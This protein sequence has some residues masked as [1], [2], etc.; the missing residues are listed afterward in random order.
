M[1]GLG[2]WWTGAR[3]T[4][5]DRRGLARVLRDWGTGGLGMRGRGTG[6]GMR[7]ITRLLGL[8]C[9]ALLCFALHCFALLSALLCLASLSFSLPS[10]A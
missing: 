6:A 2:D 1:R 10:L 3:G 9:F 4:G 5:G 8:N 7:S